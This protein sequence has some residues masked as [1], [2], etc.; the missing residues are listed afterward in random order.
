MPV[1]LFTLGPP[2]V[3][4]DG[5][6][7]DSF[8]RHR[9]RCALLSL[10]GVERALTRERIAGILWPD[11]PPDSARH[12]L[13]QTLYEIRQELSDDPF[14]IEGERIRAAD[15]LWSDAAAFET[16]A[17]ADDGALACELYRGPFLEGSYLWRTR[18]WEAWVDLQ[19]ARLGRLHRRAR[20][21][22]VNALDSAGALDDALA[23]ARK[24][25]ELD[26]LDDEANHLVIEFLART[27]RR[28]DALRHFE[29]Y[30]ALLLEELD[31]E[32]LDETKALVERIRT[33]EVRAAPVPP[34]PPTTPSLAPAARTVA[35]APDRGGTA[36][37]EAGWASA[38]STADPVGAGAGPVEA[39]PHPGIAAD[40]APHYDIV[41]L[42]GKGSMAAVYAARDVVLGR[43]VAIKVLADDLAEDRVSRRRFEREAEAAARIHH[44]NVLTVY[45]VAR[46]TSGRPG[47]VMPHVTGGSLAERLEVWGP[48]DVGEVLRITA[49]IA[50]GLAAAHRL[51][52]VH[53]DVRPANVL[54]EQEGGR[55]LL[56]D[57]GIAAVL[58]ELAPSAERLTRT[59]ERIGDPASISPEQL[60]GLPVTPRTDVYGLGTLAFT[61]LAGRAPLDGDSP[62]ERMQARLRAE[63]HRLGEYRP[64]VPPALDDLI[65]RCLARRP[66]QRPAMEAVLT[67]LRRVASRP[68]A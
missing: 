25:V 50:S 19:R 4:A 2:R 8:Q 37:G 62:L 22:Y 60:L 68:D 9:L 52:I 10:V 31:V 43:P 61:L 46:S 56:C 55:S 65:H 13:S 12:T 30:A 51:G 64:D 34:S 32:P 7:L 24:W 45:G 26:A 47:I 57:F 20:R 11:R 5:N 3:E 33:G 67:E 39:F 14:V 6:E 54:H 16:A 18:E 59:G 48:F 1:R 27:G 49:E 17:E 38:G 29:G 40:F 41:R 35:G 28:S 44:P 63:P 15:A 21:Q 42:V 53:R 58:D 36:I 66:E 23:A